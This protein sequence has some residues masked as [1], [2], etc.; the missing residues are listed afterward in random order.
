MVYE[1]NDGLM[2]TSLLN[3]EY[4]WRKAG[5][6][7]KSDGFLKYRR[8]LLNNRFL[9]NAHTKLVMKYQYENMIDQIDV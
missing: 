9:K 3:V 8:M 2:R 7:I 6:F 4:F 5:A 1:I